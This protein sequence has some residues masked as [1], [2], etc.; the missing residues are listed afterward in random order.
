MEDFFEAGGLPA[1][2]RALSEAGLFDGDAASVNGRSVAANCADAPNW[3]PDVI[4]PIETPL[5]AE[6]GIVVLRGNLAPDGA[7]IKA[8]CE[9][10]ELMTHEGPAIVFDTIEDLNARIDDPH[11]DVTPDPVLVLRTCGPKGYPGMAEVANIPIP[12]KLLAQGV[13]SEE[14]TAELQSLMRT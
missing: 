13:R 5:M 12:R 6:A 3:N 4:R 1:V 9:S 2:I 8:A 7:I 11:L 14:P 10:A